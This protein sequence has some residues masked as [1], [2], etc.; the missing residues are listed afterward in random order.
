M[1]SGVARTRQL[2]LHFFQNTSKIFTDQLGSGD[3]YKLYMLLLLHDIFLR[4][5]ESKQSHQNSSV[6]STTFLIEVKTMVRFMKFLRNPYL[7]IANGIW[8]VA[9][10]SQRR[11]EMVVVVVDSNGS[12]QLDE[13]VQCHICSMD[14]NL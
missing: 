10:A 11:K 1:Q 13:S 12:N 14:A 2:F 8:I 3:L 6:Y 4:F 7:H 9:N 5:F